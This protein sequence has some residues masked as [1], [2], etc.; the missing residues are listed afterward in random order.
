MKQNDTSALRA[1]TVRYWAG[2]A[3]A[4]A[5]QDVLRVHAFQALQR[6]NEDLSQVTDDQITEAYGGR[7]WAPAPSCYECGARSDANVLLGSEAD[8]SLCPA[9]IDK[10]KA[11][12]A[13]PAQKTNLFT[14]LFRGA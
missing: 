14:R 4:R 7:G 13:A 9:C 1:A 8:I 3:H 2:F 11:L 6:D 10:A 5:A 12:T